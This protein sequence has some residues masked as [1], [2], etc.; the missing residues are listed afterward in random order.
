MTFP[1]TART[2]EDFLAAWDDRRNF[3]L[4][5]DL[6]RFDATLP[7]A[8]DIVDIL[9]KDPDSRVQFLGMEDGPEND[10]LIEKVKTA[11]LHEILD[12]PFGLANF[13]LHN[14]YGRGKF[15]EYFQR[16]VMIPWRT[17]LSSVGLTWQ[18]CYPIIFI[19][20]KGGRSSYHVD[21]SHVLAWQVSG[22]KVFNG[23]K[24][25]EAHAP[26]ADIVDNRAAYRHD[27]PPEFDPDLILTYRMAPGDVLW[28]QLLT[29]H[30][31]DA[32]D[33]I[34]VSVNISHGGVAY[35]GRFC[36]N[37]QALR[38]RWEDHPEEAWTVDDRY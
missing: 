36:E 7:P 26:V 25:P 12:L 14:H 19:S 1:F 9:R 35:R 2:P 23:F 22:V 16:E 4:D 6:V 15:L 24:D 20:G 18:R 34:A 30:W 32:G 21:V 31:V 10:A 28:N 11:P 37:E 13:F 29:P 3:L 5:P 38:K 27:V 17:F 33:E 8:E